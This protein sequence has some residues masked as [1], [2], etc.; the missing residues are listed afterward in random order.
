MFHVPSVSLFLREH[1]WNN[2][3]IMEQHCLQFHRGYLR[4]GH[5]GTCPHFLNCIFTAISFNVSLAHS[6]IFWYSLK[7]KKKKK[8]HNPNHA[9]DS[10]EV[11]AA[12]IHPTPPENGQ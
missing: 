8:P 7:E 10:A 12:L 5:G 4:Q 1:I 9:G 2:K 11:M 6:D 3:W